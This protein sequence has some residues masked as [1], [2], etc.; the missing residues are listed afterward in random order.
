MSEESI[1]TLQVALS[2]K[3]NGINV[4]LFATQHDTLLAL[5]EARNIVR[6]TNYEVFKQPNANSIYFQAN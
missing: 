6:G 3:Y 5:T 1:Q 2:A 4:V